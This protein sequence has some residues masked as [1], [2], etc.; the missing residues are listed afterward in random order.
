MQKDEYSCKANYLRLFNE[1]L[2]HYGNFIGWQG[3]EPG[4]VGKE[5]IQPELRYYT[6]Q[7]NYLLGFLW[8]QLRFLPPTQKTCTRSF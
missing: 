5:D 3:K 6:N 2:V 8:N 4:F 1:I 7:K